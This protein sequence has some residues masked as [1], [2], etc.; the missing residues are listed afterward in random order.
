MNQLYKLSGNTG[1][2]WI[3]GVLIG[4]PLAILISLI[5]AYINVYNPIIY[6]TILVYFGFLVSIF[7]VISL[8]FRIAKCRSPKNLYIYSVIFG[9]I[10]VYSSWCAFL[11]VFYS[12]W[13]SEN[14][15]FSEILSNPLFVIKGVNLL[16]IDGWFTIYE[17]QISG[18]FLWLIWI[19]E[20]SI[21]IF[22]TTRDDIFLKEEIFCE[23][24]NR[25]AEDIDFNLRLSATD[26]VKINTAIK[27]KIDILTEIPIAK[28][29][30]S[31]HLKVNIHHCSKCDNMSTVDI[32][33]I[34]LEENKKGKIVEQK[35]DYSPVILLTNRLYKNLLSRKE[36]E[37]EEK[38]G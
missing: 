11:Y 34:K 13:G 15:A 18:W 26:E 37:E 14:I 10:V 1:S 27:N 32:D 35:D 16:S 9:I 19:I 17:F 29:N 23:N 25:W 2:L 12:R 30:E 20:S 38:S 22:I 21:I 8:V 24:C 7:V 28:K 36:E 4:F 5:Y 31:P 6:L 3:T 33:L